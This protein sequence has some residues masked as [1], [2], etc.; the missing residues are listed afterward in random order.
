MSYFKAEMHQIRFRLRHPS[1]LGRGIPPSHSP[2]P[3]C[4]WHRNQSI[5]G[6]A[7]SAIRPLLGEC[8]NECRLSQYNLFVMFC[9]VC[10]VATQGKIWCLQMLCLLWLF[11]YSLAAALSSQANSNSYKPLYTFKGWCTF[12]SL[13]V[14]CISLDSLWHFPAFVFASVVDHVVIR[15]IRYLLS[16]AILVGKICRWYVIILQLIM[17]EPYIVWCLQTDFL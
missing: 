10:Q 8:I 3:L 4:L 7:F 11:F 6:S 14:G 17:E 1:R 2:P 9:W 15:V 12:L 13:F 16:W 5:P